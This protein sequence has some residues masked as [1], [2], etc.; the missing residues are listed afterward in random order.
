MPDGS[1]IIH[2]RIRLGGDATP[3]TDVVIQE[4]EE[5]YMVIITQIGKP[6]SVV[7]VELAYCGW[8]S[9][10]GFRVRSRV[11]VRVWI[12]VVGAIWVYT[13]TTF[14]G[15]RLGLVL[16]LRLPRERGVGKAIIYSVAICFVI[17]RSVSGC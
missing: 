15:L 5:N 8:W 3:V 10:L 2:G 11:K 9:T 4:F 17:V 1:E 16:G 13:R 14:S 12:S 6:G 7:S